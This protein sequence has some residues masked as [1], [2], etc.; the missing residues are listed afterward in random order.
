MASSSIRTAVASASRGTRLARAVRVLVPG[1]T[2]ATPTAKPSTPPPPSAYDDFI[3]PEIRLGATHSPRYREHYDTTL[4][5]DLM[6]MT[7]DHRL[8]TEKP[9]PPPV[10]PSNLNL[11]E[12]NRPEK[13]KILP[14]KAKVVNPGCLPRLESIIVHSMVKDAVHSKHNLL[15]AIMA[16]RAISG[17][18]AQGGGRTGSEGVQ[19]IKAKTGAAN[20]KLRAGMP[21]AAKVEMKGDA[22]YDFLQSF[23]DF[24]LPRLREYPGL[25]LPTASTSSKKPH[26]M[27]GV[28]QFGLG[29]TAMALFPQIEANLDAY[30]KLPGFHVYF[31]SNAQG[32]GAEFTT[33]QLL[34][35]F[36]LPFYRR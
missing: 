2:Y 5:T 10:K 6:Y 16:L 13:R 4:S 33:R 12:A 19:I 26:A 27:A 32:L 36:R 20:W 25:V 9:R 28:V 7:Y 21:I 23:I 11:Y 17:E 24:V 29:P 15:P 34:S 31:K 1:R 3:L 35:G 30:S 14:Q 18:S 22:M 8:A